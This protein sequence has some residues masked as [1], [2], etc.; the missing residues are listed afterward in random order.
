MNAFSKCLVFVRVAA[1][2][3]HVICKRNSWKIS[4]HI[5]SGVYIFVPLYLE[6]TYEVQLQRKGLILQYR[7]HWSTLVQKSK[8]IK[9]NKKINFLKRHIN[10]TRGANSSRRMIYLRVYFDIKQTFAVFLSKLWISAIF[11]T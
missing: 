2:L 3:R 6:W 4:K 9:M 10:V 5:V 8:K 1:N 7:W 11:K